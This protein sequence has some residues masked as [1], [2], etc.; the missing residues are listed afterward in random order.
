M[1]KSRYF[2]YCS[3]ERSAVLFVVPEASIYVAQEAALTKLHCSFER[4]NAW[5]MAKFVCDEAISMQI[6]T[7]Y[8]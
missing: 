1:N 8:L 2:S 5:K 6:R 3:T 7:E 4:L